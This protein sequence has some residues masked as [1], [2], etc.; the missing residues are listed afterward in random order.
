MKRWP[1]IAFCIIWF[2]FASCFA[3]LT[4]EAYKAK[5]TT[6]DRF[7]E[8]I[9]PGMVMRIGSF[10]LRKTLTLVFE[11]NNKNIAILEDSIRRSSSTAFYLN[12]LSFFCCI[13]GLFAQIQELR[14]NNKKSRNYDHNP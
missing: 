4:I 12:F 8:E 2:V 14:T 7:S 11:T 6:L 10:D 3:F 9:S 5:N 13:F 1:P